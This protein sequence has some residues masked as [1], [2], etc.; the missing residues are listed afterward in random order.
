MFIKTSYMW[1]KQCSMM[2]GKIL[3]V[4]TPTL[5][6]RDLKHTWGVL[7][8]RLGLFLCSCVVWVTALDHSSSAHVKGEKRGLLFDVFLL[9]PVSRAVCYHSQRFWLLLLGRAPVLL[10]FGVT[11]GALVVI[12][13]YPELNDLS[14]NQTRSFTNNI[15]KHI[16]L[17]TSDTVCGNHTQSLNKRSKCGLDNSAR[18]YFEALQ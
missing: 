12:A 16:P 18:K 4:S 14:I 2:W 13:I 6:V 3:L 5:Y 1:N 15:Q 9:E 7:L 10:G 11:A 8:N 17:Q